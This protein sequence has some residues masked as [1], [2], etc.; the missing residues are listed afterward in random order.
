V[1]NVRIQGNASGS[2]TLTFQA[3]NTNTDRTLN[4]PDNTGTVLTNGSTAD[5]PAGSLVQFK[6]EAFNSAFSTSSSTYQDAYS[7]TFTPTKATN[8][9]LL[10]FTARMYQTTASRENRIR[11][12]RDS[13]E[14]H[15]T[16][17]NWNTGGAIAF[18][19]IYEVVD[20]PGTTSQITYKLQCRNETNGSGTIH[21]LYGVDGTG[22]YNGP[23]MLRAWEIQ[24]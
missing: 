19:G 15:E 23:P 6:H 14:I 17:G 13:T 18:N 9:V 3:P 20:I 10:Q 7:F 1:S 4:I 11:F 2:G 24:V 12:L 16:R 5:Y 8:K 21:F 22:Y